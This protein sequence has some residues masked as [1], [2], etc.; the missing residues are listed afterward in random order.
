MH[1]AFNEEA[2]WCATAIVTSV[3][4]IAGEGDAGNT[5]TCSEKNI[6]ECLMSTPTLPSWPQDAGS[7][8][9]LRCC[10]FRHIV[11]LKPHLIA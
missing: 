5:K 3:C 9:W 11:G 2:L 4:G 1:V 8:R 10:W 6:N 7:R